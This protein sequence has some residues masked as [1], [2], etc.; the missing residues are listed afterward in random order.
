MA[1]GS[2]RGD[3]GQ[4]WDLADL[5]LVFLVELVGEVGGEELVEV[6]AAHEGMGHGDHL[7]RGDVLIVRDPTLKIGHDGGGGV[8]STDV[9]EEHIVLFARG[10][11]ALDPVPGRVQGEGGRLRMRM[12]GLMATAVLSFT[13]MM[14]ESSTMAAASIMMRRSCSVR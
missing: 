14:T 2:P 13:S 1:L 9:D 4:D 5:F 8:R 3:G 6:L 10:D 7:D 11:L 12:R